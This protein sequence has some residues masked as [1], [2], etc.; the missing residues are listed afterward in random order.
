MYRVRGI[1]KAPKEV[2]VLSYLFSL[3]EYFAVFNSFIFSMLW[4][5]FSDMFVF[6]DR[7]SRDQENE[8]LTQGS[9]WFQSVFQNFLTPILSA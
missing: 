4:F 3:S 5:V 9:W 8:E 2:T 7:E 1:I 6:S